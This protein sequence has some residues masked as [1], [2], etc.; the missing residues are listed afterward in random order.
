ME[1]GATSSRSADG[2]TA[3]A[4]E[5]ATDTTDFSSPSKTVSFDSAPTPSRSLFRKSTPFNQELS[6]EIR[7]AGLGA[8]FPDEGR[9]EGSGEK[10]DEAENGVVDDAAKPS[11]EETSATGAKTGSRTKISVDGRPPKPD[12]SRQGQ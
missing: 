2:T 8:V 11:S 9:P 6:A 7:K 1:A 12:S 5:V 3:V 10:A 4:S